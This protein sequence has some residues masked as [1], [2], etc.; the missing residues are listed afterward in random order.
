[1]VLCFDSIQAGSTNGASSTERSVQQG[2][3]ESSAHGFVG[4]CS[5]RRHPVSSCSS[6][7]TIE[8]RSKLF[9]AEW[10]VLNSGR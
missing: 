3:L 4:S 7:S 1:M 10:K 6:T 2:I 5:E 9:V 8:T